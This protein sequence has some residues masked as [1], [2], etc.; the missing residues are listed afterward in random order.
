M[1]V[2]VTGG[3]GYIGSTTAAHLLSA[4]HEVVVLDDLSR[5]HRYAVPAGCRLV[6]A[7]IGDAIALAAALDGAGF[8]ALVHFA[9]YAYVG[10]SVQEPALYLRN[11]VAGSMVLFERAL[12]AGV[13]RFVSS[14]SCTVY[15]VPEALPL[16]EDHPR[17]AL[18][19]YGASKLMCE[20]ALDWLTQGHGD[21][22]AV[23]LRYF[24]AAGA[25][26]ARGEDHDPETHL[27]PL[28][29][30]AAA[31][32]GPPLTIFGDDYP[33]RDGTCVRDYVHV[34]DLAEAH[35]RAI[36]AAARP[37][38][39]AYNVGSGVGYTVREVLDTVKRVTGRAVPHS[40]GPRRPGDAP[41]LYASGDRIRAELGWEAQHS[42]LERIVADAWEWH[43]KRPAE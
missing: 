8:E 37:G 43:Q 42:D 1:K 23:A 29:L 5:G 22:G 11:N 26:P 36:E 7:D 19:P 32:D 9:A 24:N 12:A 34:L 27:I 4:G 28:A 2:L 41:G 31:G 3:A 18:S 10:E 40:M 6:E 38:L 14:S 25:T 35:L 20:Q 21:L 17:A 33:T 16:T 39:H 30:A 13:R 15:G